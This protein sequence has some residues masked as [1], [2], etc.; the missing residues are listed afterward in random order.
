VSADLST[1]LER[2][3]MCLVAAQA[4]AGLVGAWEATQLFLALTTQFLVTCSSV[5]L[6]Y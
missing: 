3:Q 6:F 4:R 2:S 1:R 5:G